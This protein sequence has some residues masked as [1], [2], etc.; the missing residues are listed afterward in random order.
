MP[1]PKVKLTPDFKVGETIECK[2][3]GETFKILSI[4][5]K[6]DYHCQGRAGTMPRECAQKALT[7]VQ[8]AE[9][10]ADSERSE[11]QP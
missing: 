2:H 8:K 1:L 9:L 10:A 5:E 7:E 3:S 4:T 11:T 6:G